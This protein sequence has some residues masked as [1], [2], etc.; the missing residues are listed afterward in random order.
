MKI[1]VFFDPVFHIIVHDTFDEEIENDIFEEVIKNKDNFEQAKIGKNLSRSVKNF[2][3]N[4]VLY[5]DDVYRGRRNESILL[6]T[7]DEIFKNIKIKEMLSS[8]P[9]PLSEFGNT[10]QHETQVSRYGDD[11]QKYKWHVDDGVSS[12]RRM[13]T[14]V[15]YFGDHNYKG[16]ELQFTNSPI[17]DGKTVIKKPEIKTIK[18]EKNMTVFFGGHTPHRVMP[19]KSSKVFKKGRFS[20]NCWIGYR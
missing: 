9:Y 18:P 6:K 20:V 19:T 8:S 12:G 7:I 13:L 11:G 1:E 4:T 16:G 3:N 15:H 17:Y 5:Y 2:R 14:M 10:N